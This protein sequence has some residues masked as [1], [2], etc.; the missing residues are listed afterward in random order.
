M[1]PANLR[2]LDT[3]PFSSSKSPFFPLCP[4]WLTD[5]LTVVNSQANFSSSLSW[6]V[7]C[8]AARLY[9]Q[10]RCVQRRRPVRRHADGFT[11]V[12][13][14]AA[15]WS[16]HKR[17][18]PRPPLTL[19]TLLKMASERLFAG[20][21]GAG[22]H[23][24]LRCRGETETPHLNWAN[25]TSRSTRRGAGRAASPG[26][27]GSRLRANVQGAAYKTWNLKIDFFFLG[28]VWLYLFNKILRGNWHKAS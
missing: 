21:R 20:H 22:V 8:T 23:S 18:S 9:L 15:S 19:S 27:L 12:A 11:S 25:V 3:F 17:A 1:T 26:T 13:Q 7:C 24:C 28:M 10:R 2:N 6:A 16:R 4:H 5:W 14:S